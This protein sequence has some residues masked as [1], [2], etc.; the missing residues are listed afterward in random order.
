MELNKWKPTYLHHWSIPCLPPSWPPCQPPCPA[1]SPWPPST[2]WSPLWQSPPSH[3]PALNLHPIPWPTPCP[4]PWCH[5]HPP[6][7]WPPCQS[8]L[9]LHIQLQL[10]AALQGLPPLKKLIQLG[11]RK[12]LM[13][14]L[15][16][17]STTFTFYKLM[18]KCPKI[19]W[20]DVRNLMSKCPD[21][22]ELM[23]GY[24]WADVPKKWWADVQWASVTQPF[25]FTQP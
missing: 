15:T 12:P 11:G 2:S 18:S 17:Q 13:K 4:S 9:V 16:L 6:P 24:W 5:P 25:F 3:L 19:W 1:P 7:C 10:R 8:L 22:D 20:A 14:I 21:F 23:S